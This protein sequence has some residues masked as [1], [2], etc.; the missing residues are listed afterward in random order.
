MAK[1]QIATFLGTQ[2]GI[3]ITGDHAYAYSGNITTS[4]TGSANTTTAKFTS[5]KYY[6]VGTVSAQ[7]DSTGD[8]T[9][10]M[11]VSLNGLDVIDI[12]F[13]A[14]SVSAVSM[15]FPIPIIIPPNTNVEMKVGINSG[16]NVWTT[17]FIGRIYR[18]A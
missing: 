13:D 2:Q 14:S 9:S 1:K 7:N 6:F 5:G 17:Q 12:R 4:G 18:D 16:S 10:F 3:S 8:V 15:D 11:A